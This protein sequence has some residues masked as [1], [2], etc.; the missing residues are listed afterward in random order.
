[1]LD[2]LGLD[3]E[4]GDVD[5]VMP[6]EAGGVLEAAPWP[7][8]EPKP[9]SPL[10][11]SDWLLRYDVEGTTLECIGSMRVLIDGRFRV[12]PW[13]GGSTV[14]VGGRELTL[15]PAGAWYHVYRACRPERAV[16]L[17]GLIGEDVIAE[18]A[19]ALGLAAG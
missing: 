11:R 13:W 15:A 6:G 19:R 7:R 1:M 10:F 18:G 17:G 2:L 5:L 9:Q 16:V 14:A 3:V 8:L 12:V 4:V